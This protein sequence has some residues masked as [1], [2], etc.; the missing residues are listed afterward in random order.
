MNNTFE[1]IQFNN[2]NPI[3]I[4]V[5]NLNYT[6]NHW[7]DALEILFVL[8]G[9][10]QIGI[11]NSSYLLQ[12]EDII[13]INPN[14]IHTTSAQNANLVLAL[15][16]SSDWLQK[17]S[18]MKDIYLHCISCING[19]PRHMNQIR[20][21]LAQMMWVYN[22]QSAC[23]DLRL[24]SYLLELLYQLY[25]YFKAEK[26]PSSLNENEKYMP[27]LSNII[28]FLHANYQKDI[29]LQELADKEFLSISYISRFF[30]KHIG[31]PYK[32]YVISLRLEH[33]VKDLLFT[34]KSIT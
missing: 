3:K 6:Q 1:S 31:I 14:E 24:Q 5:H 16:I 12:K 4:F 28:H 20:K 15:Q 8:D 18:T 19:N 27:R 10:I 11:G 17:N 22:N 21:L 25:V 9:N 7:H 26:M 23:F 32:E 30:K 33:A 29:S 13:V 34:D 2:N